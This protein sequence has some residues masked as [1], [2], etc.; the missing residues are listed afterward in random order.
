MIRKLIK[1]RIVPED[2]NLWEINKV[3][4]GEFY[5]ILP[6][7][8]HS[9]EEQQREERLQ[10]RPEEYENDIQRALAISLEEEKST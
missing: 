2:V 4:D 6:G 5:S 10:Q 1:L 3:D 9:F 7:L 8:I